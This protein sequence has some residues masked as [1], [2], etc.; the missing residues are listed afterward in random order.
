M[1]DNEP[2]LEVDAALEH[3]AAV[4]GGRPH[5]PQMP[6]CPHCVSA[7]DVR[8]LA[9]H[10]DRIPARVMA[11]YARK[12][13]T[14]WGELPDFQRLLPRLLALTV[15]SVPG[16]DATVVAGKLAL[17][18]WTSW[19]A[20]EREAVSAFFVAWWAEGLHLPPGSPR[21]TPVDRL[22]ALA[23]ATSDLDAPLSEWHRRLSAAD[24][25]VRLT[26]AQHLAHLV[27]SS[28]F[29]AEDPR[30]T[31]RLLSDPRGDG[32]DRLAAWLEG[33][34]TAIQLERVVYDFADAR[35][36][37][38]LAQAEATLDRYR[39]SRAAAAR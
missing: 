35:Q 22:D 4:L 11:R 2:T 32:A 29:D 36:A 27:T 23:S 1:T 10:P 3:L 7:A 21:P 14:T 33:S 34:T 38:R 9:E 20:A 18:R 12:A 13:L 17:S 37:D 19:P 8:A 39:A 24:A 26:A 30:A 5:R 28:R 16:I 6:A 15:A 25:E 31:R